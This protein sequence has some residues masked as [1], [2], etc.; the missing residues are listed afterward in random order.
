MGRWKLLAAMMGTIIWGCGHAQEAYVRIGLPGDPGKVLAQAPPEP[1]ETPARP[2][3]LQKPADS[4]PADLGRGPTSVVARVNGEPILVE[5]ARVLARWLVD[6]QVQKARKGPIRLVS[7]DERRAID[8]AVR[9]HIPPMIDQLIDRDLLYQEAMANIPPRGQEILKQAVQQEIDKLLDRRKTAL[10]LNSDEEMRAYLEEQGISLPA[11]R[12]QIE[13]GMVADE[14]VRQRIK[15]KIDRIDRAQMWEY[16]QK[17]RDKY[18]RPETVVWHHLFISYAEEAKHLQP[19]ERPTRERA[20]DHAALVR[21][22][23]LKTS[24]GAEWESLAAKYNDGPSRAGE[25]IGTT[26]GAIRPT[27]LEELVFTL[28]VG[29]VS[30]VIEGRTG[31][32]IIRVVSRE[33]AGIVPFEKASVEIRR[34]LQNKIY[35]EERQRLIQDL[36]SKYFIEKAIP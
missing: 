20:R 23:A 2:P 1:P 18:E 17:N 34:E 24:T 33:P 10:G 22:E 8:E 31:C 5:D 26:R 36:R 14:Y 32:H 12:R 19:G 15:P 35:A 21:A 13:R 16:Y 3:T 4:R 30:D 7:A 27:E 9:R 11:L 28:P 25:G 29:Q 6:E